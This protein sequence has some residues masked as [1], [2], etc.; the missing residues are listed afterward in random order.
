MKNKDKK[1][2]KQKTHVQAQGYD[3]NYNHAVDNSSLFDTDE[4]NVLE[5]N[6]YDL[7]GEWHKQ[8]KGYLQYALQLAEAR[9]E[10][11]RTEAE[12]KVCK[13]EVDSTIR[14]NPHKYGLLEKLTEVLI[15]N[16]VLLQPKHKKAQNRV[17]IA[18]EKVNMLYAM[19][20]AWDHRKSALENMVRLH[21]QSY[22]STPQASPEDASILAQEKK[23][24][25]R[26]K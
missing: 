10:L 19:V 26:Q 9:K 3:D 5:P 25:I 8:P 2:K 15:A 21:G 7:V 17:I 20:T 1:I 6:E 11:D 23:K 16:T 12:F 22:F 18:Q 24:H 14:E 13:A 4:I